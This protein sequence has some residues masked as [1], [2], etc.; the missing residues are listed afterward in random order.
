MQIAH[1]VGLNPI[2][3]LADCPQVKLHRSR[4][5]SSIEDMDI[6]LVQYGSMDQQ[7]NEEARSPR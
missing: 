7:D 5:P 4:I 2:R 1:H 3:K 6:M